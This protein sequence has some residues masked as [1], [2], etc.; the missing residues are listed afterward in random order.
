MLLA[1]VAQFDLELEHMDVK[2]TFLYGDLDE[3]IL[4]RQPEGYVEKG[5]EDYV[6][7]LNRS[8]YGLKQSP[9]QWNRRFDKFMTRISF[10]RSQFD[11]CVYFRFRPGNSFVI[12][13]LYVDDTLIASNNVEEVM[14]VK[15]KLNKEFKMKDLG[16]TSRILMIDIRRD[17]KH[18]KLCLS[19]EAC[20]RKILERYGMSNSKP[21][22]TP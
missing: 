15:A 18:S 12:L 6:C 14:R 7:K 13:L 10:D 2:T 20:L 3:T 22:V 1:M 17:R 8:L 19:Q 4:M 16:A 21:V 9:R 11:H 5:K